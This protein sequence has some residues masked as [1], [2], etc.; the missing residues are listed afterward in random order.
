MLLLCLNC[1]LLL[2]FF[3]PATHASTV[4]GQV[5]Q[6]V[7]YAPQESDV[8]HLFPGAQIDHTWNNVFVVSIWTNAPDTLV[9]DIQRALDSNSSVIQTIIPPFTLSA[10]SKKWIEYNLVWVAILVLIFLAG[11]ACGSAAISKCY[12]IKQEVVCHDR[13]CRM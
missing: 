12:R 2:F 7:V 4:T 5:V 11:C 6:F 9:P 3:A 8:T 10:A 1:A 13:R